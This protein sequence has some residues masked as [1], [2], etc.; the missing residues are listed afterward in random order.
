MITEK[1]IEI[2]LLPL[3]TLINQLPTLELTINADLSVFIDYLSFSNKVFPIV[4]VMPILL[5]K[6]FVIPTFGIV[7]SLILRIKSFIPTMGD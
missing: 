5:F 1:I 2:L 7:W 3:I 6:F 4:E